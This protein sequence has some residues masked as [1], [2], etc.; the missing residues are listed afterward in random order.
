MWTHRKRGFRQGKGLSKYLPM[1]TDVMTKSVFPFFIG[2]TLA[3][4]AIGGLCALGLLCCS[5]LIFCHSSNMTRGLGQL[6]TA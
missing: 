4:D 5:S 1:K 3:S 6:L 2:V